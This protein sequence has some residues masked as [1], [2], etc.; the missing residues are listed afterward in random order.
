MFY[1][2]FYKNEN[3]RENIF[4]EKKKCYLALLASDL[5][6]GSSQSHCLAKSA[7]KMH[8][9]KV[10]ILYKNIQNENIIRTKIMFDTRDL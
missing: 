6:F 5:A 7:S 2:M 1:K 3:V 10:R 4:K 9:I 8:L